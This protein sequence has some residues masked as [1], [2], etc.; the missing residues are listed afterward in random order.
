MNSKII[1]LAAT[2]LLGLLVPMVK[3][4]D[5]WPTTEE[6][7][8]YQD[9]IEDANESMR[10]KNEGTNMVNPMQ[11][12]SERSTWYRD[13]MSISGHKKSYDRDVGNVNAMTGDGKGK[14]YSHEQLVEKNTRYKNE[15]YDW[16]LPEDP[17]DT[18]KFKLSVLT[19]DR[20]NYN[21]DFIER[22]VTKLGDIKVKD[23]DTGRLVT[24]HV[25]FNV[26][27]KHVWVKED[28]SPKIMKKDHLEI[29][30]RREICRFIV[31]LEFIQSY[32]IYDRARKRLD[33]I[34]E[35]SRCM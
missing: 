25:L 19:R 22:Y 27:D 30:K 23:S 35:L 7:E 21:R 8:A 10:T 17:Y 31:H 13:F 32:K 15:V 16:L 1:T 5:T 24:L 4:G 12:A 18:D 3:A 34:E 29:L 33:Q 26:G 28:G 2:V 20:R 14:V 11:P 6:R 9:A